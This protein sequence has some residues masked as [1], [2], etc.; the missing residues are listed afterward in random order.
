MNIRFCIASEANGIRIAISGW[1]NNKM[2]LKTYI[3]YTSYI[4]Y[5]ACVGNVEENKR[6]ISI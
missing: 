6:F 1:E 5:V 2:F 4:I 3:I